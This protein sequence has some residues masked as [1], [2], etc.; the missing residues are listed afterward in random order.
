MIE[1]QTLTVVDAQAARWDEAHRLWLESQASAHTRRA[2][3]LA[4]RDCILFC[5]AQAWEIGRSDIAAWVQDMRLRDLADTTIS[6]RLAAVSSFYRYV[7]EEYTTVHA[8]GIERPLHGYN[9]AAGK[10]L[11]PRVTPYGKAGFLSAEQAGQL[12]AAI[13][14]DTLHGLQDYALFAG[15]LFLG[16][17][18]SEWRTAQFNRFDE[19]GQRVRYRFDGKGRRDQVIDVAPPVWDAVLAY[20]E[21]SGMARGYLFT[22]LSERARNLPTVGEHW[23]PGAR[24]IS[25]SEVGRRL[26]RYG[27][28]AD[29]RIDTLHVHTLR[30]T[31]AMLRR[32]A[33]DD[34][35][36]ISEF[37]RHKSLAI[38]QIYLQAVE[39]RQ[40]TSWSKVAEMLFERK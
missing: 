22:A 16:H 38:T 34:V 7:C 40:D 2:Y 14:R 10:S 29:L 35:Q 12:L 26:K 9:P 27:K 23:E 4:V 39:G 37:L 3:D 36:E 24:P 17:R 1:L 30:H 5:Q 15:Y 31:A 19:L 13:R 32:A 18:N 33:G 20:R 6:Q 21:A 25:A 11:R 28:L 8:D